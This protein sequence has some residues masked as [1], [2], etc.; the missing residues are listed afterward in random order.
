MRLAAAMVATL[1]AAAAAAAVPA[2]AVVATPVWKFQDGTELVSPQFRARYIL[3]LVRLITLY[4][5]VLG[6]D[7]AA[8]YMIILSLNWLVP[9]LHA[10]PFCIVSDIRLMHHCRWW[11]LRSCEVLIDFLPAC[12]ACLTIMFAAGCVGVH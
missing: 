10:P 12:L 4:Y 7:A 1:P 6:A 8:A 5:A 2:A 9:L 3:D 11:S